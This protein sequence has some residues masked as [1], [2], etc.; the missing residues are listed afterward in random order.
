MEEKKN[1]TSNAVKQK[2]ENKA[3]QKYMV[4]LRNDTDFDLIEYI[5]SEKERGLGTTEIFRQLLNKAL[6][7]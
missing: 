4:R 6:N 1:K 5:E 3:Y 2:W 7:K